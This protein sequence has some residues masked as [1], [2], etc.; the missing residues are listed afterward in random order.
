MALHNCGKVNLKDGKK[1]NHLYIILR[2][3]Y[4]AFSSAKEKK[5]RALQI[6]GLCYI[7]NCVHVYMLPYYM[8]KMMMIILLDYRNKNTNLIMDIILDKRIQI[9]I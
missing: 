8:M 5:E 2:N 1:I 4:K 3:M 7:H 9:R 6:G